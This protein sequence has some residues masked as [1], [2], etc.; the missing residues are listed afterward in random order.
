HDAIGPLAQA[1][2]HGTH[3]DIRLAT[4][5][6]H[7]GDDAD[8]GRTDLDGWRELLLLAHEHPLR[9]IDGQVADTEKNVSVGQVGQG[10][11]AVDKVLVA[12]CARRPPG[13]TPHAT[14]HHW[15]I[16]WINC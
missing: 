1:G 4:G 13:K 3:G 9:R 14:F 8:H 6:H 16:S 12:D 15:R 7:T 11:L 10:L 5:H 2:P